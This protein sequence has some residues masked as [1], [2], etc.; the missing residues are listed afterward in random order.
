MNRHNLVS[1]KTFQQKGARESSNETVEHCE[2]GQ[3]SSLCFCY[4]FMLQDN[5]ENS[6]REKIAK[7][8]KKVNAREFRELSSFSYSVVSPSDLFGKLRV[9]KKST[10]REKH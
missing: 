1:C 10:S 7:R 5:R 4:S 6:S 3:H 2:Q 9:R 8:E